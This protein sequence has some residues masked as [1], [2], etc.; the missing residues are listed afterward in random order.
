MVVTPVKP[1]ML[2]PT[3]QLERQL[4]RRVETANTQSRALRHAVRLVPRATFHQPPTVLR[5]VYHVPRE[6]TLQQEQRRA[7]LVQRELRHLL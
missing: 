7:L 2:D 4:A 1:V 5:L 6:A 3:Q